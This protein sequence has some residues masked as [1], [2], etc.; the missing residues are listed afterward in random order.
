MRHSMKHN[1][2]VTILTALLHRYMMKWRV[3]SRKCYIYST[4]GDYV[5]SQVSYNPGTYTDRGR[6][7]ALSNKRKVA[8]CITKQMDAV[9]GG[10]TNGNRLALTNYTCNEYN[11]VVPTGAT[12]F[13]ARV[14]S[15]GSDEVNLQALYDKVVSNAYNK[16]TKSIKLGTRVYF[17]DSK[18]P[19]QRSIKPVPSIIRCEDGSYLASGAIQRILFGRW[20]VNYVRVKT[21]KVYYCSVRAAMHRKI[22]KDSWTLWWMHYRS[23]R[24][25]RSKLHVFGLSNLKI[26]LHQRQ[27]ARGSDAMAQKYRHHCGLLAF[28][29]C[30]RTKYSNKLLHVNDSIRKYFGILSFYQRNNHFYKLEPV[31]LLHHSNQKHYSLR[32]KAAK[33]IAKLIELRAAALKFMRR[34][35]LRISRERA[36]G[37]KIQCVWQR[38]QRS[39]LSVLLAKVLF[40]RK[41]KILCHK[42]HCHLSLRVRA[43]YVTRRHLL[44]YWKTY[45]KIWRNHYIFNMSCRVLMST[46]T[47]KLRCGFDQLKRMKDRLQQS[48]QSVLSLIRRNCKQQ[49]FQ[50]YKYVYRMVTYQKLVSKKRLFISLKWNA[51]RNHRFQHESTHKI[52][53]YMPR[54]LLRI[55]FTKFCMVLNQQRMCRRIV[56]ESV[57]VNRN[58]ILQNGLKKLIKKLL[59]SPKLPLKLLNQH[60][61]RYVIIG[62]SDD[63]NKSL[64]FSTDMFRSITL[65]PSIHIPVVTMSYPNSKSSFLLT[66]L[67][68]RAKK[69]LESMKLVRH[70]SLWIDNYRCNRDSNRRG[71]W[72]HKRFSFKKYMQLM[73]HHMRQSKYNR[74]MRQRASCIY[75]LKRY[76]LHVYSRLVT[77]KMIKTA[78]LYYYSQLSR[79]AIRTW[80]HRTKILQKMKRKNKISKK[81]HR[82][83]NSSLVMLLW[84]S[85]CI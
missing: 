72:Q 71:D 27:A 39:V 48:V 24:H 56:N 29:L 51:R 47:L 11:A 66:M 65:T 46:V 75:A 6:S 4:Y 42:Y 9:L 57:V 23:T 32:V 59:P 40:K 79:G 85:H 34:I 53:I 74:Y 44:Q 16:A 2:S 52:I 83:R 68:S 43:T 15:T 31:R 76:E 3:R 78:A 18:L 70:V 69:R 36:R 37:E 20:Y 12:Y 8:C 1:I 73:Q 5:V 84:Q 17:Y 61:R 62:D 54:I 35:R 50:H 55:H 64:S 63:H 30:I 49:M 33:E 38:Q 77:K 14:D 10:E 67:I 60:I 22:T 21:M 41:Y 13:G 28:I 82:N 19:N 80:Y 7:R 45:F 25:Y 81:F 26:Q 58:Y